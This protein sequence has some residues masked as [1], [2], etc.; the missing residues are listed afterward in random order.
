MIIG[1][2]KGGFTYH[3]IIGYSSL[4]GMSLDAIL[5]WLRIRKYGLK[6]QVPKPLHLYSR[7]ACL[8]WILA[9][10]TGGLLVAIR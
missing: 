5:L 4:A 2:S 6:C 10:I 8:W 9:F 3:G 7:Y 1:S